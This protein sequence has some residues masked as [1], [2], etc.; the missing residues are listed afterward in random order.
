MTI[1][2]S[3]A[4][5]KRVAR[6]AKARGIAP[7]QVVEEA[8]KAYFKPPTATR[9][10]S[11]ARRELRALLQNKKKTA[12]FIAEVRRARRAAGKLLDD[13]A[14]WIEHVSTSRTEHGSP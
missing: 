13:N 2:L 5:E 1:Q 9:Q 8:L 4:L 11:S 12:D 10:E 6:E 14:E 3:P 7:K